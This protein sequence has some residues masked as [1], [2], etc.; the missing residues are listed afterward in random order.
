[1]GR[2]G[3]EL[4]CRAIYDDDDDDDDDDDEL[5]TGRASN[6]IVLQEVVL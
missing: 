5:R 6:C 3:P 2:P 1:M 4:G